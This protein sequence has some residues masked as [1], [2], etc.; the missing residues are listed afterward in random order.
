MSSLRSG[1]SKA[2]QSCAS[3]PI[4][5]ANKPRR[6][7][8]AMRRTVEIEALEPRCVLATIMVTSTADGPVGEQSGVTLRDAIYASEHRTSVNG[9]ATGTGGDTIQF[10]PSLDGQ[11]IYL[12]QYYTTTD[13][14]GD[15]VAGPSAFVIDNDGLTIDGLTGLT[16]GITIARS[17]APGT[18]DFRLFYVSPGGGS[19]SVG[20]LTLQGLTLEGGI[21]RGFDGGSAQNG[22][23]AGGGS[24]GLGGAIFVDG[25]ASLTVQQSTITG[26]KAIG[27]NGGGYA[28]GVTGAGGGAGTAGSGYY[29]PLGPSA[30]YGAGGHGG[31]PHGGTPGGYLDTNKAGGKW[32]GMGGGGGAGIHT[33]YNGH[34]WYG[35][36]GSGLD[37]GGGGGGITGPN[38]ATGGGAGDVGGGGGG[39]GVGKYGEGGTGGYGAGGYSNG[40]VGIWGGKGGNLYTGSGPTGG[41]GGGGIGGGGG[42]GEA[43]GYD[44]NRLGQYQGA[45]S[46]HTGGGGGGGGGLGG[47]IAA[48]HGSITITNSTITGNAAQ[49]GLPGLNGTWGG[50]GAGLGA[51]VFAF[52]SKVML[53]YD[54]I[55]SNVADQAG[56]VFFAAGGGGGWVGTGNSVG[57]NAITEGGAPVI[58]DNPL[59]WVSVNNTILSGSENANGAATSDFVAWQTGT[60]TNNVV[61]AGET[62]SIERTT[63]NMPLPSNFAASSNPE[64]AALASNGGTTQT[65]ALQQ[66][67]PAID[68]GTVVNMLYSP[69]FQ[70]YYTIGIDQRGQMRD[71]PPDIGTYEYS[72]PGDNDQG[73]GGGGSGSGSGGSGSGSGGSGSGGGYYSM[74][75][76]S[77]SGSGASTASAPVHRPATENYFR[78]LGISPVA[79]NRRA[80]EA[81]GSLLG[82]DDRVG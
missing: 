39:G 63:T 49:G 15:P 69:D 47:A 28:A 19:A 5:T 55:A 44:A 14:F 46:N 76:S 8:T 31:L 70:N 24:G 48:F 52:N 9:S 3:F 36:G 62:N 58:S 77:V 1:R 67:S 38:A 21:A 82:R 66:G 23:G 65:M 6:R 71:N 10:S 29:A 18:P 53:I 43:N 78:L 68:A 74:L 27:G 51:G 25:T 80:D 50:K 64:L 60:T 11:T 37:G 30:P 61:V 13:D 54:T 73:G 42:G 26:N 40:G 79:P 32:G 81:V 12:S 2:R 57:P 45:Q 7:K 56:S 16:Q 17:T 35:G 4:E 22:A 75:A 34:Q 33:Y 72:G 20:A 59:G 41:G